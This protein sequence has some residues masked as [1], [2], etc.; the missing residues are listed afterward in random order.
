[1]KSSRSLDLSLTAI[2]N[3]FSL[4]LFYLLSQFSFLTTALPFSRIALNSGKPN[5]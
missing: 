3:S 4:N 1:M 2:P 5:G